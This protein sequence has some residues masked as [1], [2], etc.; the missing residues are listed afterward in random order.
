LKAKAMMDLTVDRVT[1]E[2]YGHSVFILSIPY[3]FRDY[4]M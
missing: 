4:S 2:F 1:F 3:N